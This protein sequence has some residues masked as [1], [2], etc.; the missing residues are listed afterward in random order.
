MKPT[1]RLK[2]LNK[3]LD[4]KGTLGAG[5]LNKDGSITI[6][7]EPCTIMQDNSDLVYTLFPINEPTKQ[8][9]DQA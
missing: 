1:H 5:W 6:V 9:T 7:L 4:R 2:V 3:V 8:T